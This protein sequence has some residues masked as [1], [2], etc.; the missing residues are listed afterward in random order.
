MRIRGI[1][2]LLYIIAIGTVV[3]PA[4]TS[5]DAFRPGRSN[6]VV[7]IDLGSRESEYY[8]LDAVSPLEFPLQGPTHL[9]ILS[10]H[11]REGD[12][13]YMIRVFRDGVEVHRQEMRAL[14][15]RSAHLCGNE[16]SPVGASRSLE[17]YVPSGSHIYEARSGDEGT[18]AAV[19]L[20]KEKAKRNDDD[21]VFVHYAPREFARACMLIMPSGKDYM[22]YQATRTRPVVLGVN[23]PTELIIRTRLNLSPNAEGT[24]SYGVEMLR[25]GEL[26]NTYTYETERFEDAEYE[27]CP[28]FAP[29]SSKRIDVKVPAGSWTFMLRPVEDGP[30]IMTRTLISKD[31]LGPNGGTD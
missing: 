13:L 9:K 11:L 6:E 16:A 12:G 10:R 23:G 22:H 20:Y 25:N 17:L 29:G 1:L 26:L 7:C 4:E 28:E 2:L 27:D 15:S 8:R 24:Q 30:G 31:A 21:P 3:A 18:P 19:R 14:E 5:W